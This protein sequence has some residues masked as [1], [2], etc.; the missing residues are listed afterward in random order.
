M[1]ELSPRLKDRVISLG[2]KLACLIVSACLTSKVSSVASRAYVGFF[3]VTVT[4]LVQGS[5]AKAILLDD[6]VEYAFGANV[7][8]Q[9]SA[10]EVL[11]SKFYHVLAA[12]IAL[13]IRACGD[14]IPVVT[15]KP[16][17][18]PLKFRGC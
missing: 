12:E 6:V 3:E 8:D 9:I 1:G 18:R 2:E 17:Y 15:G 4:N 5:T 16:N 13:R 14:A 7:Q 10:S 11:G